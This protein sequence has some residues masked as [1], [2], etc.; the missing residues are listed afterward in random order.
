MKKT[1]TLIPIILGAGVI[2]GIAFIFR[3]E[4]ASLFNKGQEE[5]NQDQLILPELD[6]EIK[7]TPGGVIAP[8]V[9]PPSKLSPIGTPKQ[10][11]DFNVKLKL[12]DKGQE[13]AK[14]QQILNRI[15]KITKKPKV[16]EDGIFGNGTLT[17]LQN[18]FSSGTANLYQLYTALFAINQADTKNDLKNWFKYYEVLIAS[19]QLQGM[20]RKLYFDKNQN[21]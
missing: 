10:N 3:K 11:W 8:P 21:L 18:L 19:P 7:V 15:A 13:V 2:G 14:A 6:Q 17:R 1:N 9:A 4:I 20:A 12:G 5:E 16:T